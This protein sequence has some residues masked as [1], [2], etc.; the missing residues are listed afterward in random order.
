M[1]ATYGEEVIEELKHL[2]YQ[3]KPFNTIQLQESL[4][5]YKKLADANKSK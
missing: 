2:N 1:Q 5:K 3:N 4:E